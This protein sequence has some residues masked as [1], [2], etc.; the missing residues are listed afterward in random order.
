MKVVVRGLLASIVLIALLS[1]QIAEEAD[2]QGTSVPEVQLPDNVFTR[3][4]AKEPSGV[5]LSRMPIIKP[6]EGMD[7][8]IIVNVMVDGIDYKLII[9]NPESG[10]SYNSLAELQN[11][12]D[13]TNTTPYV[14]RQSEHPPA[15]RDLQSIVGEY[16]K[17]ER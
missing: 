10:R 5:R 17:P 13:G 12:L 15:Y 3:I 16:S 9:V 6:A 8:G 14:A 4:E 1:C 11:D 2:S 7:D